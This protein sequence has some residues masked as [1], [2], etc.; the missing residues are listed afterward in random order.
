M[1]DF[2]SF[3]KNISKR[4]SFQLFHKGKKVKIDYNKEDIYIHVDS[5]R[6]FT[7]R[8]HSSLG[9][10]ETIE[11]I[12]KHMGR[13]D[14]LYDIGANVGTYSLIAAKSKGC[15]VYSFEPMSLNYFKL[16]RNIQLNNL[17]NNITPL[18]IAL[19]DN[20]TIDKFYLSSLDAGSACHSFGEAKNQNGNAFEA[21]SFQYQLSCTLDSFISFFSPVPPNHI[22]VDVD[23]IECSILKGASNTLKNPE[24]KS[25]MVEVNLDHDAQ[26][27]QKVMEDGGFCL[28]HKYMISDKSFNY[29]FVR[30]S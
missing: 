9:E 1:V 29:L 10:P 14:V 20:N 25:V 5:L 19:S 21:V 24:L 15:R 30:C 13:D 4:I 16:S 8:V 22:K 26:S 2:I 7:S 18:N 12:E 17:N 11:W 23:G 27:V 6:E 3:F 28:K